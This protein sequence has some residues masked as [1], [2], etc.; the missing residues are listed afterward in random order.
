MI[1]SAGNELP[2][3]PA[4]ERKF[5]IGAAANGAEVRRPFTRTSPAVGAAAVQR[6]PRPQAASSRSTT[7]IGAAANNSGR[8][9]SVG[10][11]PARSQPTSTNRGR[12][13]IVIGLRHN[14]RRKR[15][16]GAEPIF[17]F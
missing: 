4:P 2:D 1:G 5:V 10:R 9:S 6:Q 13:G 15:L 3:P 16:T 7:V 17:F 8:S 14:N 12:S 11:A